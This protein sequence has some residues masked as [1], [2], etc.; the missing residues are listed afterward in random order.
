[1]FSRRRAL[2]LLACVVIIVDG[3][4]AG[5]KPNYYEVLGVGRD[6]GKR[7]LKR[8]FRKLS[9]KYHP[10]KNQGPGAEAAKD[11]PVHQQRPSIIFFCRLTLRSPHA[12]LCCSPSFCLRLH[13]F[14]EVAHAYETL[15]DPEKKRVYDQHGE[16]GLEELQKRG[17]GGGG[18]PFDLFS[19]MGFNFGGRRKRRGGD[20]ERRGEDV[21]LPLR[22]TLEDIYNGR[23][24]PYKM[25]KQVLC[26]HCRGTGAKDPD[27]DIKKCRRCKGKGVVIERHQLGPGFVQQVQTPCRDCNGKG[28]IV[29]RK[30]PQCAGEKLIPGWSH[31]VLVIERGMPEGEK[32]VFENEADEH[33]DHNAGHLVFVVQ[34]TPHAR[35]TREGDDLRMHMRIPLLARQRDFAEH[36]HLCTRG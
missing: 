18:D 21:E 3:V 15:S 26:P 17:G 27:K 4:S 35:F 10:D 16:E 30:C 20:D 29:T 7:E 28:K 12:H 14:T 2:A 33:P 31:L 32:I 13:R 1:M 24:Q 5:D 36:F 23:E 9:L 22:V 34:T 25:R 19:Q 11:K 8:A 6:A